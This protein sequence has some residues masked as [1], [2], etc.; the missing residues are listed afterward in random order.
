MDIIVR[1]PVLQQIDEHLTTNAHTQF[2]GVIIGN[3][4]PKA[5]L[6][7]VM[8]AMPVDSAGPAGGVF[9]FSADSMSDAADRVARTY[10]NQR[11]VGWYHSRPGAGV[12]FGETEHDTHVTYFAHTWQIAYVIDP[13]QGERGFFGWA[14]RDVVRIPSWEVTRGENGV[15]AS[16]PVDDPAPVEDHT[17]P[18]SAWPAPLDGAESD[19]AD[20]SDAFETAPTSDVH[21]ATEPV[22]APDGDRPDGGDGDHSDA[23]SSPA[24][25]EIGG[26]DDVDVDGDGDSAQSV[27]GSLTMPP[28]PPV[29]VFDPSMATA[30][31]PRQPIKKS[32]I[33]VIAGLIV[34][35]VVIVA[36][37][38]KSGNDAKTS[39]TTS[40]TTNAGSSS[41]SPSSASSSTVASSVSN[42]VTSTPI[43][44][45]DGVTTAPAGVGSLP[46]S[47]TGVATPAARVGGSTAACQAGANGEYRPTGDCFVALA[48]GNVVTYRSGAVGCVDPAG[49]VLAPTAAVFTVGT[50]ADPFAVTAD[51]VAVASCTDLTYAK[52]VLAAGAATMPGLCGSSATPIDATS[53]RCFAQNTTTGAIV[54]VVKGGSPANLVGVCYDG[55]SSEPNALTWTPAGVFLLWHVD[56]VSF[57]VSKQQFVVSASRKGVSA[58]APLACN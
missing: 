50:A 19:G 25:V 38:V 26:S 9:E 17:G 40:T 5:G 27:D 58:T 46:P 33:A 10:P 23:E 12:Y 7:M 32:T 22:A 51:G 31:A 8:A 52:T 15:D 2:G 42:P 39:A 13:I 30:T 41:S 6:V 57:D 43:S 20:V 49:T 35:A 44:A 11:I 16:L 53:L 56:S 3:A 37:I 55:S 14:G 54:A 48:N 4:S 34:A 1:G 21:W 24:D 29:A 47:P 18:M 45:S 36:V 28:V